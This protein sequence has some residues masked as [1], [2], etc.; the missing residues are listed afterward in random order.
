MTTASQS[1]IARVAED[2]LVAVE[3]AH[4][5]RFTDGQ[6]DELFVVVERG[7]QAIVDGLPDPGGD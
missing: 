2:L 7:V 5:R 1:L 3:D 6:W 4:D